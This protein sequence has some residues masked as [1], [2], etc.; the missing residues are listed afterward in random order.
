[1]DK[2]NKEFE[3]DKKNK[4]RANFHFFTE[5]IKI[6]EEVIKRGFSISL[7][8]VIT[9]VDLDKSIEMIPLESLMSE[10]DSPFAAPK[11]HRGKTNTPLFVPEIVKKIAQVKQISEQECNKKLI[12]N[13]I[14][15]FGLSDL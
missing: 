8:G 1:L 3:L 14:T 7:P 5:N 15:F 9:F 6:V 2:K 4:I 10:T 11:P 13:A 12:S